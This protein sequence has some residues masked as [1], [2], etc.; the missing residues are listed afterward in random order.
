MRVCVPLMVMNDGL[1]KQQ[2]QSQSGGPIP[3]WKPKEFHYDGGENE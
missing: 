2:K 1:L 3:Q